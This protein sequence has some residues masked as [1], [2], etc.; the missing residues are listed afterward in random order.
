VYR[1]S[2]V[3]R[4]R[5]RWWRDQRCRFRL[6]NVGRHPYKESL[7]GSKEVSSLD[8]REVSKK[9]NW[10]HSSPKCQKKSAKSISFFISDAGNLERGRGGFGRGAGESSYEFQDIEKECAGGKEK[11][12]GRTRRTSCSGRLGGQE[13]EE[14]SCGL[15]R[16]GYNGTD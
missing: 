4:L 5:R 2:R 16:K 14:E 11:N 15:R 12:L 13:K 9:Q 1:A 8:Q 6:R 3:R 10:E 7:G